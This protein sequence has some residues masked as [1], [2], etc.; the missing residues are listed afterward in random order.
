MRPRNYVYHACYVEPF[1]AMPPDHPDPPLIQRWLV[2]ASPVAHYTHFEHHPL[3]E[4]PGARDTVLAGLT[5]L[6]FDYHND[7]SEYRSDLEWL[8]FPGVAA[9]LD[10]RPRAA[11]TRMG[12]FGEIVASEYVQHALGYDMP[13]VRL[14]YNPNPN[15]SMKGDD[16]LAFKFGQADGSGREVLVGEAK[17]R[18]RF[19]TDVVE[20]AYEQLS[21]SQRRPIPTSLTFVAYVLRREGQ[22]EKAE[23]VLTFLNTFLPHRKRWLLFIATSNQPRDPFACVQQSGTC[24]DNLLA[25]N[26]TVANLQTLVRTLF[27]AEVVIDD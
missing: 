22:M 13:I 8:G 14:R 2:P 9:E 7:P 23:A 16:V 5:R 17:V 10:R 3:Q 19:A 21:S 25:I 24:P 6:V 27:E 20:E 12:N 26:I 1:P 4:E 15:Q 11:A 18:Q